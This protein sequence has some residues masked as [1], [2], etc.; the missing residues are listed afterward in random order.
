MLP[1]VLTALLAKLAESGLSLIGNAVLAKG[2]NLVEEKLGVDIESELATEEGKLKLLQLQVDK[3]ADLL[4]FAIA[5]RKIDLE[6]YQA[7]ASDRDSARDMNKTVNESQY[8]SWLTKN[9]VAILALIVVVGGGCIITFSPDADVR[10]GVTSIVTLVLGFYFGT[11]A[12]SKAKDTTIANL[13]DGGV[14]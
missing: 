7:E 11:S 5:N 4:E 6:F 2:K 10:L 13:T 12:S 3:E 9:I 14:R 8:S 1:I